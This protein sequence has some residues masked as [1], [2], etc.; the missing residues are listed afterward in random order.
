MLQSPCLE[1]HMKTIVID[2]SLC[3]RSSF[4][5]KCLNNIKQIYQHA[6]K[7]DDQQNLKDVL[8]VAMVST[9]EV[10]TDKS[11][12]FPMTSTPVKKPSARKSLCFFT[13]VF[14]I[15]QKTAKHCNGGAK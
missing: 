13:N 6:G 8:D 2:Q 1:N 4:E 11:P 7:F 9:L 10:V 15:K 3:T 14:D 12:S 5:H